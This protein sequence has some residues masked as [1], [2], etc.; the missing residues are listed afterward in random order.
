MKMRQLRKR[1][2]VPLMA[3]QQNYIRREIFRNLRRRLSGKPL[4]N[5]ATSRAAVQEVI[6]PLLPRPVLRV[7]ITVPLVA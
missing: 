7:A 3:W 2:P 4:R 1:K 5:D 6:A